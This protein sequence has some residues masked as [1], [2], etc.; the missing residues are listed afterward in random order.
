MFW[1]KVLII[2]SFTGITDI[3][4]WQDVLISS[5]LI[6][7]VFFSVTFL[8][9]WWNEKQP[10]NELLKGYLSDDVPIILFLAQ[11]SPVNDKGQ[12]NHQQQYVVKYSHPLPT[13]KNAIAMDGRTNIDPLWAEAD[14]ECLADIHNVLGRAGKMKDIEIGDLIKDWGKWHRPT[15]T[16]G[17][18]PKSLKLIDKCEPVYF[19][20]SDSGLTVKGYNSILNSLMPNDAAIIQKTFIKRSDTPVFL[21]AGL[22]TTG[23]G[24]AGYFFRENAVEMGKLYG[25]NPFCILLKVT[26]DEGKTSAIAVSVYPKPSFFR[27]IKHPITYLKFSRKSIFP[28]K[29]PVNEKSKS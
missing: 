12:I 15:F 17:F 13:D 21:L 18:N 4:V 23:T 10:L 8:M 24:A 11:L 20:L 29:E 7:I 26:V 3:T 16:I 25:N 28:E 5:F 1:D 2:F 22:G 9:K 27:I 19:N 6:P 14:G